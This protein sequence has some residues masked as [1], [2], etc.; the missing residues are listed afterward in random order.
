MRRRG[1]IFKSLLV[2]FAI[3]L[4]FFLIEFVPPNW[5]LFQYKLNPGD[6]QILTAQITEVRK[7]HEYSNKKRSQNVIVEWIEDGEVRTAYFIKPL[8]KGVGDEVELARLSDGRL[9]PLYIQLERPQYYAS[10]FSILIIFLIVGIVMRAG[11]KTRNSAAGEAVSFGSV[12]QKDSLLSGW[13]GLEEEDLYR[14]ATRNDRLMEMVNMQASA[15]GNVNINEEVEI[16]EEPEPVIPLKHKEPDPF[17][18]YSSEEDSYKGINL[19]DLVVEK[20]DD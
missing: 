17:I 11:G 2:L 14:A 9:T 1:N 10:S 6:S 16:S 5:N 20:L 8:S 12:S 7:L 18:S 4:L 13:Q 15:P 3:D 19:D